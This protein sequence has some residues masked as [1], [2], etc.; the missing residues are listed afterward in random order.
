LSWPRVQWWVS[1]QW[2]QMPRSRL[3][4]LLRPLASLVLLMGSLVLLLDPVVFLVLASVVL[5]TLAPEVLLTLAPVVL[6]LSLISGVLLVYVVVVTGRVIFG[7]V[8]RATP[9]AALWAIATAA[10]QATTTAVMG[11]ETA[12]MASM[13]MAMTALPMPITAVTTPTAPGDTVALWFAPKTER[14]ASSLHPGS[15][16]TWVHLFQSHVEGSTNQRR[17]RRFRQRYGHETN[18]P[19]CGT[20]SKYEPG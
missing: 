4:L 20:S 1:W 7:A 6:E 15:E 8:L 9:T 14:G 16:C 13:S 17:D 2:R 18:N 11:R 12:T 10:L 19:N 5:L 3:A